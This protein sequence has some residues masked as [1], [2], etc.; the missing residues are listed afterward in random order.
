MKV[1]RDTVPDSV[2]VHYYY[3]FYFA[4]STLLCI[5]RLKQLYL[6]VGLTVQG[7][8]RER[9]LNLLNHCSPQPG[10]KLWGQVL[11]HDALEEP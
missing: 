3:Y 5:S 11:E 6:L 2:N 8:D 9:F 1:L 4:L 7:G 10:D